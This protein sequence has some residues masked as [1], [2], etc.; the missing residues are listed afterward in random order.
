MFVYVRKKRA[1]RKSLLRHFY[2]H[3]LQVPLETLKKNL[4][5]IPS[6]VIYRH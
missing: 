2:S 3:H 4:G 1:V 6:R 5:D